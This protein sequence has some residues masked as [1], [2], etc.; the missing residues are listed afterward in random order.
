MRPEGMPCAVPLSPIV[1][2]WLAV[3]HRF[4]CRLTSPWN[5]GVPLATPPDG[6]P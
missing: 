3:R 4:A 2:P 6:R 5:R 1:P